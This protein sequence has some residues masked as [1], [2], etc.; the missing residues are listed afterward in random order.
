MAFR[1]RLYLIGLLV[2]GSNRGELEEQ[3]EIVIAPALIAFDNHHVVPALALNQLS[4]GAL[5]QARIHGGDGSRP[6]SALHQGGSGRD[7]VAFLLDRNL[8]E[9][10]RT[11]VLHQTDQVGWLTVR[12][13]NTH[14]FAFKRLAV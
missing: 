5:G 13:G 1:D 8:G 7:F 10:Y 11:G 6:R 2:I 12:T 3:C 14:G 9:R 4:Q